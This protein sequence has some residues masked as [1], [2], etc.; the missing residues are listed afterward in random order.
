MKYF[1]TDI[2]SLSKIG[3]YKFLKKNQTWPVNDIK[4]DNVVK[5]FHDNF[6]LVCEKQ[7]KSIRQLL[8]LDFTF[9]YFVSYC[10]HFRILDK[11]LIRNGKKM[12][13]GNHSKTFIKINHEEL[14]NP[15]RS[16]K[17][18]NKIKLIFKCLIKNLK[19]LNFIFSKKKYLCIGGD[20][21]LKK[22][23]IKKYNISRF[24]TYPDLLIKPNFDFKY[25][26]KFEK[27]LRPIFKIFIKNIE[28]EFNLKINLDDFVSIW[29]KRYS[30]L[31]ST[32]E[33]T[34][35]L[36]NNFDGIL[37]SDNFKTSSRFLSLYFLNY[38]KKSI[39]FDHGNHANG[40]RKHR[41]LTAQLLSYKKFIT[42]S[43]RSKN[44]LAL[45]SNLAN[46]KNTSKKTKIEFFEN[47]YLKEIYLKNKNIKNDVSKNIMIMGWPMNSRKYFD[48][49]PCSFFYN[50]MLLEIELIKYLKK[51]KFN[52]FY[53]AHP[54]RPDFINEIY[55]QFAD[56]VFFE[57]FE[58]INKYKFI[59][60]LIFSNSCS[61]T[62]GYSLCTDKKI[63]LLYNEKYFKDHE[64]SLKK[65]LILIP[66]RFKN[67]YIVNYK[68]LLSA[69]NK[70]T[71]SFNHEYVK[72]YL[73]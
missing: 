50:K 45:L 63:I 19:N 61:S 66:C 21:D 16:N 41:L 40:R 27:I 54:E 20:T 31:N 46:T 9:L 17:T 38:K 59:D 18:E 62:F 51:K 22:K 72:N 36:K 33:E 29:S 24:E 11:I 14:I 25:R 5:K 70:K 15:F 7:K 39:S 4:F 52:V 30:I 67:K 57:K 26:D 3:G 44:S 42:I 6:F 69:L 43:K 65:R 56:K 1:P 2:H 10:C 37:V 47:S 34:I 35:K 60:T 58:N 12:K 64:K 49:G 48:E 8:Y 13:I 32:Y 71:N 28:K 23:Y 73:I 68:K 53:K 55:G